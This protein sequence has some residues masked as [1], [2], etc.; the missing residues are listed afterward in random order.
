MKAIHLHLCESDFLALMGLEEVLICS[1]NLVCNWNGRW[2]RLE[3]HNERKGCEMFKAT[4]ERWFG[5]V[6][7]SLGIFTHSRDQMLYPSVS[8]LSSKPREWNRNQFSYPAPFTLVWDS[9][10]SFR[11]APNSLYI[12]VNFWS[13]TPAPK[14]QRCRCL[15]P[16]QLGLLFFL[17][18]FI[19]TNFIRKH[20]GNIWTDMYLWSIMI[21]VITRPAF[22]EW[23]MDFRGN[24]CQRSFC[25]YTARQY[26]WRWEKLPITEVRRRLCQSLTGDGERSMNEHSSLQQQP[27]LFQGHICILGRMDPEH[28]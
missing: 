19:L 11:T 2:K 14:C 24:T 13:S 22:L 15:L 10:P 5:T 27:L 7:N 17:P 20:P 21:S 8:S 23:L 12:T 9:F 26:F 18:G 1:L 4:L 3:F 6:S 28:K 25:P 16:G